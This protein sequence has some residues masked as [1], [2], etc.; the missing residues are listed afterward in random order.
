MVY[1]KRPPLRN[2]LF[3]FK[4]RLRLICN[5]IQYFKQMEQ[6]ISILPKIISYF[7]LSHLYLLDALFKKKEILRNQKICK[8]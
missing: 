3:S 7:Q 8:K 5:F 1:D 6:I 2:R 4:K